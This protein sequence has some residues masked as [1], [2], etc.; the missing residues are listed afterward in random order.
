MNLQSE[1]AYATRALAKRRGYA[2]VV[3]ATLAIGI[4]ASSAIF[5]FV[6]SILLQPLPF[7]E[8]EQLV[9]IESVRGGEVGR[10]S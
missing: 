6:N 4:G 5:T 9:V 10:V 7:Q 1:I 3:V 2:M 8:P